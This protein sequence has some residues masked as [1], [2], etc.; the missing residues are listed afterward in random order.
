MRLASELRELPQLPAVPRRAEVNRDA[1]LQLDRHQGV[2][3][4][5]T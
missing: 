2:H 4:Q 1:A 3:S 5:V